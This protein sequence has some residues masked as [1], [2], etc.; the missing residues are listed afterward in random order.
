METMTCGCG[1]EHIPGMLARYGLLGA[2][3]LVLGTLVVMTLA[4][5]ALVG[6]VWAVGR[7][8]RAPE[9]GEAS[10]PG[11]D[12]D[13]SGEESFLDGFGRWEEHGGPP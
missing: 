2:T 3:A 7:W 6:V 10:G 4:G 11:E 9:S 13:G 1:E 8:R 5:W 12:G